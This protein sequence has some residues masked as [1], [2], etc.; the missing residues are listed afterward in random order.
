MWIPEA[1][2]ITFFNYWLKILI[3]YFSKL[4]NNA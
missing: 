4:V 3:Y 2:F 1:L